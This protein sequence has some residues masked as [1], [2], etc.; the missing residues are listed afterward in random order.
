[1]LHQLILLAE[2]ISF[3]ILYNILSL[4]IIPCMFNRFKRFDRFDYYDE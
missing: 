1:M 4:V 3:K 2:T